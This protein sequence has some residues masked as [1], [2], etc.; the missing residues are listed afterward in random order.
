MTYDPN[1]S[2]KSY[3]MGFASNMTKAPIIPYDTTNAAL[4]EAHDYCLANGRFLD[5]A[6]QTYSI[7][8][9]FRARTASVGILGNGAILDATNMTGTYAVWADS[10]TADSIFGA[11]RFGM[12]HLEIK[13]PTGLASSTGIIGL[14][15]NGTGANRSPRPTLTNVHIDGFGVA[16]DLQDYAYL[17]Q[18]KA[19]ESRGAGIGIR[20]A[21]GADS[22]E[23]TQ[24]SGGA[25]YN[26]TEV[27]VAT[28]DESSEINFEA[29]SFDYG[30]KIVDMSA[31]R[32]NCVGCHFENS[33]TGWVN[34]AFYLTGDGTS[35]NIFGGYLV[36][37]TTQATAVNNIINIADSRAAMFVEGI[38][39]Q[40]FGNTDNRLATGPGR[41]DFTNTR[42]LANGINVNPTRITDTY[43]SMIDGGFEA[44]TFPRDYWSLLTDSAG[45][46]TSRV[47]GANVTLAQS[48]TIAYAGT[49]SLRVNKTIAGAATF[50]LLVR[51]K[52]S[53]GPVTGQF[54]HATVAGTPLTG[55]ATNWDAGF[56]IL[57]GNNADG[58]P[59]VP[60]FN[61]TASSSFTPVV[62]TWNNVNLRVT[63]N[64][65][66]WATH[67]YIRFTLPSAQTGDFFIDDFSVSQ[68]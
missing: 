53:V 41:C 38:T 48:T 8:T 66:A 56:T 37:A 52:G 35:L 15:V 46:P 21:V 34:D 25:I 11:K 31:G 51:L 61:S 10:T 23:N 64:A 19:C 40:N 12:S 26:H 59:T 65:P 18:F 33:G 39:V 27:C 43:S 29:V 57:N 1:P 16:V 17:T 47:T 49:K 20:Q 6:G 7:T 5:L 13:G 2:Y 28:L 42:F 58:I 60:V 30:P 4:Q 3:G 55:A 67:F 9:G 63:T 50:V 45:V 44:S 68:W 36:S 62:D 24:W 22:G 32:V 14:R 54:R